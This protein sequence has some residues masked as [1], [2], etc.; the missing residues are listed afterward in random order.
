MLPRI[1]GDIDKL[2]KGGEDKNILEQLATLLSDKLKTIW[3]GKV[4]P[5][6]FRKSLENDQPIE[7][8]CRAKAK[9]DWMRAQLVNGFT[10]FWP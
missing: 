4:R 3:D 6:L 2:T 1:E 10:S 7:I 5:D 8:E 9:L